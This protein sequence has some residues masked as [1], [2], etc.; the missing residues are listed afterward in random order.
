MKNILISRYMRN[1]KLE[2]CNIFKYL[3]VKPNLSKKSHWQIRAFY[4]AGRILL[5]YITNTRKIK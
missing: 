4:F 1:H 2:M 5:I 3:M